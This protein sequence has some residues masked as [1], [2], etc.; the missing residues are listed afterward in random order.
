[1]AIDGPALAGELDRLM[2]SAGS[3]KRYRL[4]AA[5]CRACRGLARGRGR[6]TAPLEVARA[7][8]PGR[9]CRRR[10]SSKHRR[11]VLF[12]VPHR[13]DMH[14]LV[15]VETDRTRRRHDA[16]AA[17]GRMAPSRRLCAD[18]P[19]HRPRPARSTRRITASGA[20][21]RARTAARRASR[22]RRRL[23]EERFGV[24]LA[25]CPLE[26]KIS[27]MNLVKAR[28]NSLGAL[29]IVTVDNPM[30]RRPGTA[31]ATTA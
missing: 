13:L 16:A 26:E 27:E 17:R 19:G 15:P 31:S 8:P 30:A 21:T 18:R 20:T 11:G 25:G 7:M 24:T 6:N 12:K 10:G 9:R 4:G 3:A 14:H 2:A 29:A 22:K 1:M 28:G 23:Q 5:L